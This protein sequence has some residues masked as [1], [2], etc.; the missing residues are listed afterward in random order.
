MLSPAVVSGLIAAGIAVDARSARVI[1]GGSINE[2]YRVANRHGGAVFVKVNAPDCAEMFAAE[3]EGL[4]AIRAAAA[5]RVPEPLAY[6]VAD[7]AAWLAL[8]FLDLGSGSTQAGGRLGE[9]LAAQHGH[10]GD[11]FGWHRD[12]TIGTT[13]QRNAWHGDWPGFWR[14]ERLGP[15]LRYAAANGYGR[16]TAARGERLVEGLPHLFAGHSPVPSLL[17]GDLWGGNWAMTRTGEPV[18]F[19]PAVYYGDRE[20]DLAMSELF[21]GF[22]R[23]FRLAY[24]AAWPLDAGYGLRRDIYN[25][26][27]VLNHLNLFGGAYLG[28]AVTL[29]D[30]LLAVGAA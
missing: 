13:P 19:D 4:T 30:R 20:C 26:Y 11:R 9:R 5:V 14:E 23:Q 21:G 24:E 1:P 3:F 10:T 6:G 7:G 18:T 27:H 29:M 25:L 15:Q 17:H 8:E 22:P 12:N 2:C 28:Q 16:E